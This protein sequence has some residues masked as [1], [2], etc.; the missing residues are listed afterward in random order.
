MWRVNF[1]VNA[2][3]AGTR[4]RI[5]VILSQGPQNLAL[6]EPGVFGALERILP[7]RRGAVLDVGMNVGQ[8]LLK[9][10]V[11]DGRR[12][13]V[14]F[15]TNPRCCHYVDQ[16]IAAN[17]FADCTI[18]PAGLSDRNGLATLWLRPDVSLDPS[19]TTIDAVCDDARTLRRQCA[20]V[21]R[22]DDVVAALNID[23]VAVIKIDT[24]GGE[25]EVL[26]GLAAAIDRCR[27]YIVCEILP[28]GDAT[29]PAGRTR[30]SRQRAVQALLQ[31][32]NYRIFRLFSDA[33]IAEVD[34]IGVHGDLDLSNYLLVPMGDPPE[35]FRRHS[36]NDQ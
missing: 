16:L 20:S 32:M 36:T 2:A 9:V 25:L 34:D 30:L 21:C 33:S 22:G 10:K 6:L 5:P 14:G 1:S 17:G 7:L 11:L 28:V 15:D 35:T 4:V 3:I 24:E 23:E 13:Y 19:A 18:V 31:T 29:T 12:T 26:R 8:T 27:P